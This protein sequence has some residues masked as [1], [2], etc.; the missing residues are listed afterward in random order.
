MPRPKVH[1]EA[2][3][4]RLLEQ[5]GQT[6]STQGLGALSLRRLAA[7]AETST[8]AVYSLF[9]GKPA[10]LSALVDEAFRRLAMH[11]ERVRTTDDPCEDLVSLG[12][13]YRESALADPHLYDVMFGAAAGSPDDTDPA[14]A[15]PA[16][17]PLRR[18]ADRAAVAGRLRPGAGPETV[19]LAVWAVLH[20]L[21]SAE[22]R[23]VGP[24]CADDVKVVFETVLRATVAAWCS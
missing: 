7:D 24:G 15:R 9:G 5:A 1:D 21:T 19:T 23:G 10:L 12:L 17:V 22:L 4:A 14:A 20:G 13:A 6:L 2:L 3:R 18:A 11:L 8:T 16:F